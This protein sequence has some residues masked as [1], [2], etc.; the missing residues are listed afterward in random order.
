MKFILL[1]RVALVGLTLL[2]AG[3]QPSIP[4]HSHTA[5]FEGDAQALLDKVREVYRTQRDYSD[6]GVLLLSY[7]LNGAA[8]LEKHPFSVA[9]EDR[10]NHDIRLFHGRFNLSLIHI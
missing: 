8:Q 6:D 7:N 3:C 9:F 4:G 10:E 1:A 2:A 5:E